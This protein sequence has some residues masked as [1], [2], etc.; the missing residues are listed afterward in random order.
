MEEAPRGE[1]AA[2]RS[3]S[4]GGEN[5]P[6]TGF[7]S[8]MGEEIEEGVPG[9]ANPR[10]VGMQNIGLADSRVTHPSIAIIERGSVGKQIHDRPFRDGVLVAAA[11]I[12]FSEIKAVIVILRGVVHDRI[13]EDITGP[14]VI[15]S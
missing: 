8:S 3:G 11:K 6:Q 2:F 4:R 13:H 10:G 12:V 9:P 7:P 5:D 1:I 14:R 15:F